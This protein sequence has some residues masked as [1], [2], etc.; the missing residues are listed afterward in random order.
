M[1]SRRMNWMGHAACVVERGGADRVLVGE[2]EGKGPLGRPRHRWKDNIK[3]DL[4]EM[5]WGGME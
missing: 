5:M 1:K 3:M 4:Q 2:T